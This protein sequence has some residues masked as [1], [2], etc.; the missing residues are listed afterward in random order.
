VVN[1]AHVRADTNG[2]RHTHVWAT[3]APVALGLTHDHP[4]PLGTEAHV[5]GSW[6]V[7]VNSISS[8]A[9]LSPEPPAGS[10]YFDANVTIGY[11]G[12]GSST[13]EQDL[14]WQVVGSHHTTYTPGSDPCPYPGPQPAL[15]TYDPLL[16]GQS[17]TGYVCWQIAENDASSL[18][19][20]FG[21]G[22]LN[23][24]ATTWFALH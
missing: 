11:F 9:Q 13:P 15:P 3:F 2:L 10:A 23:Y 21:S 19:L 12:G 22:T 18:E 5:A 14:T 8:N 24:P 16:S 4:I 7:Q 20:Y 17:V 1:V 6:H